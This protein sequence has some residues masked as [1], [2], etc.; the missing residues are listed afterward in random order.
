MSSHSGGTREE[1]LLMLKKQKKLTVTEMALQLGITEMGVRRH[2]Q[3]LER[4]QL[5]DFTDVR[6]AMG[7]PVRVYVLSAK[8]E[9]QFPRNYSN[10]T[11]EFLDDI[12][13][14]YGEDAVD[15]LFNK[16]EQRLYNSYSNKMEQKSLKE[17]V[18]ELANIQNKNGYMVEWTEREDGAF[19]F[20][21]YNCPIS[22]VANK[23]QTAC[24]CELSLFKKVLSTERV[25][26]VGCMAKGKE[27]CKYIIQD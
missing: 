14:M 8:G 22:A 18:Q 17:R 16:R 1:I 10:M 26:Q 24:S 20:V 6:Q 12:Q 3:T 13:D 27:C 4:D 19:E 9:E 2:L 5:L 15:N 25:E 11:V 23:Y 21:E 7:R